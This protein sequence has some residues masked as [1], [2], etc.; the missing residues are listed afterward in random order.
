MNIL[1]FNISI[2][3]LKILL[4]SHQLSHSHTFH[5]FLHLSKSIFFPYQF[6]FNFFYQIL[7][8]YIV[9]LS[10]LIMNIPIY[11]CFPIISNINQQ[12]TLHNSSTPL[13]STKISLFS[14]LFN[15]FPYQIKT[16]VPITDIFTNH[17]HLSIMYRFVFLSLYSIT[18][19]YF[20]FSNRFL[21]TLTVLF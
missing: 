4:H 6:A 20:H 12:F 17:F 21:N 7:L 18:K 1:S 8:K 3:L 13:L 16:W 14:K 9:Y 15:L 2:I 11:S 19:N 5:I 10:P